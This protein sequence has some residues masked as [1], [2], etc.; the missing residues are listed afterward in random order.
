M[1]CKHGNWGL[2]EQCEELDLLHDLMAR[3]RAEY[4]DETNRLRAELAE[5]DAEIERLKERLH[6][7]LTVA[8][9]AF[10]ELAAEHQRNRMPEELVE[11]AQE[12]IEM[13]ENK[14]D[15]P[16]WRGR[17]PGAYLFAKNLLAWHD[18]EEGK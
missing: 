6:D 10:E 14:N 15:N 8:R 7:A 18:G 2:C 17:D 13:Y 9:G 3:E 11:R 4:N 1:S 12:F 5:R 16:G